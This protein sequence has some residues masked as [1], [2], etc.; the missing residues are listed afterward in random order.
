MAEVFH[1][2]SIATGVVML[3]IAAAPRCSSRS[4]AAN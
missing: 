1:E 4:R 2:T 3:M